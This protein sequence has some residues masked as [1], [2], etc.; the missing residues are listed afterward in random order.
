MNGAPLGR[1]ARGLPAS[2]VRIVHLGLGGFSRAHQVWATAH[3]S[4]ADDWGVAGF[5]GRSTALAQRL[6]A[7]DGLYTLVTRAAD[8]DRLEVVPSLVEARA[9]GDV[10]RLVGLVADPEVQV[11]TLTVT[12][13]GYHRGDGGADLAHPAVAAD[14]EALRAGRVADLATA[15]G[16]LAAG[17]GARARAGVA[18][19][20]V[21]PCDNLPDNAAVVRDAVTALARAAGDTDL[22]GWLGGVGWV[23]TMVDRIT[24]ATTDEDVADVR[25]L[26]GYDDAAPVVTEPFTEWVLAGSFPGKRPAWESTGARFVD[27]V[28]PYER[29]KLWLLNGGHSLL[30]YV[31]G[32]RGH[33]T[34]ADAVAD[35]GCRALLEQWWDEAA[36]G[37]TGLPEG[38]V[39]A[40]RTALLDRFTNPRIRHLL[41]QIVA[42]GSQKLPV[43][44]LPTLR[45]ARAEGRV[46]VAAVTVL[47]AWVAHLR[48][49][50][51]P[52]R[53]AAA[54]R[55]RDLAGGPLD[56]AVPA[57]LGA[58]DPALADDPEVVAA[59]RA[60][61]T[62]LLP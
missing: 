26:G 12:E 17:L 10:D 4:D 58:L 2:P 36:P 46:P 60:A 25:R 23:T 39:P 48:G 52:V 24:P 7:Q 8:G 34:V 49:H 56:R 62:D 27:D 38:D 43:R 40:Y 29:R 9:G 32:A 20:A 44:I 59:V 5:T 16:R 30:A 61:T 37:L 3:A 33:A 13:A 53:D 55:L 1:A 31:G 15:P 14:V 50:G 45:A 18:P 6:T 21:V 42:D 57:V 19:L 54:D 41:A 22:L 47:G 51:T 28:A 35:P 11:V